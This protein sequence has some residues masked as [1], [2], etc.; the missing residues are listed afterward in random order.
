[1]LAYF[2][3]FCVCLYRYAAYGFR[4]YYNFKDHH[5]EV[6]SFG[7]HSDD[8]LAVL[9]DG[10]MVFYEDGYSRDRIATTPVKIDI[11]TKR[12]WYFLVTWDRELKKIVVKV[13]SIRV[14]DLI[15]Y[16]RRKR[17]CFS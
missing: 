5:F 4:D 14:E 9:I 13:N 1:M 3:C 17:I 7:E 16:E 15:L 2:N 8:T 11:D 10:L 12:E 6:R